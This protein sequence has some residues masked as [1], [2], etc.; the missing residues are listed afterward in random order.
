MTAASEHKALLGRQC[1]IMRCVSVSEVSGVYREE[2][3]L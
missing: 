3:R 2:R 1:G